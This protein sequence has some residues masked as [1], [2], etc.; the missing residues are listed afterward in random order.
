MAKDQKGKLLW[1]KT[2]KVNKSYSRSEIFT[3]DG[4]GY[5]FILNNTIHLFDKKG[6]VKNL[7][8]GSDSA[9]SVTTSKDGTLMFLYDDK[10]TFMDEK[11]LGRL[12]TFSYDNSV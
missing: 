4:K 3:S 8:L 11:S 6:L 7:S 9:Y 2:F 12:A 5:Y 10:I 1:K